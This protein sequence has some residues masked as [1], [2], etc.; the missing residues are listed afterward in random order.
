M[1]QGLQQL[2]LPGE[3][4]SGLNVYLDL[5]QRW[6]ATYNLTAIRDRREM[7]IKHLFDSLAMHPYV[8][9]HGTMADLGSGAGL[10]GIP[11]AL[12]KPHLQISLVESAG[13]KA[14]FMREAARQLRL[15]NVQVFD[16]RAE[17][18]P[19]SGSFDLI[20][21]R[22]LDRIDGILK[23][24]GHLLA[25][26]GQLLAM[27]GQ[28]PAAEIAELGPQWRCE[29][30]FALQVPFLGAERHLAIIGRSPSR[31]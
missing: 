6:N 1:L 26:Q 19:G 24:G 8:P 9:E 29:G 21:A 12:C 10:P 25:E 28:D 30:V 5:L 15:N 7:L 14:R 16:C 31:A 20:T 27:K 4:A 13:K 22:A 18:V 17:A 2:K 11:L 3:L 23:V